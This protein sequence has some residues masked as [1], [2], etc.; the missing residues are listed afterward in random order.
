[1]F[2]GIIEW[3]GSIGRSSP[4]PGGTKVRI[5]CRGFGGRLS[6]G[7]SVAVDGVCLTVIARGAHWFEA[8]ISPETARRSTLGRLRAGRIVNLER[9]LP[10]TGNV[11]GHFVQGHVDVVSTVR[12]VR[13]RQGHVDVVSTVRSVRKS[14]G[15]T[16]MTIQSA[17][18]YGSYLV[19][20]GS[21]AVNGVSL[22][23]ASV[24]KGAF[25]VALIPHTLEMT[26]LS[27]LRPG[28]PVNIEVDIL[29]KY[30]RS[31]LKS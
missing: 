7:E 22:T 20:K 2:T 31:F 18:G 24:R 28:S 6:T 13:K 30:V 10:A 19:E 17:R 1:M 8:E 21:V 5:E 15:F 9:P 23:V 16:E 12:S 26:N 4:V 27:R 14:G 3:M 29:A 11:G 25:T